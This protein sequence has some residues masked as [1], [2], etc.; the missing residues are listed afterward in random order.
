[1]SLEYIYTLQET[2]KLAKSQYL[3]SIFATTIK[4][5]QFYCVFFFK[6]IKGF[7]CIILLL[8][9]TISPLGTMFRLVIFIGDIKILLRTY[10]MEVFPAWELVSVSVA[11]KQFGLFRYGLNNYHYY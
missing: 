2:T 6:L 8:E 7:L 9:R 4:D 10:W 3:N 1:M 5:L 11:Y